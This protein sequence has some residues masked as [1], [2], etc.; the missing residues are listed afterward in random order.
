[1]GLRAVYRVRSQLVAAGPL[2]L[3]AAWFYT[4]A[5][6]VLPALVS[7]ALGLWSARLGRSLPGKRAALAATRAHLLE[8]EARY[9]ADAPLSHHDAGRVLDLARQDRRALAG[10]RAW[11]RALLEEAHTQAVRAA[12]LLEEFA[13]QQ[14]RQA[15]AREHDEAQRRQH[16]TLQQRAYERQAAAQLAED[17]AQ[18]QRDEIRALRQDRDRAL[19]AARDRASQQAHEVWLWRTGRAIAAQRRDRA[20]LH[21]GT[22]VEAGRQLE[23]HVAQLLQRDGFTRVQ[24]TGAPGDLGADVTARAAGDR[25]VVVQCKNYAGRRVTSAEL[26]RFGGTFQ[27]VHDADV[28]LVVTTTDFTRAAVAYARQ[29]GILLID[30]HDLKQWSQGTALALR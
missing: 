14:H 22:P 19:R 16:E 11:D 6:L 18:L 4:S 26:Q 23:Q 7:V 2:L 12:A 29:A 15:L 3:A 1:M 10:M 17:K 21:R 20:D 5:L 27:T 30:G 28:G 9:R 8:T 25:R 13:E 24:V